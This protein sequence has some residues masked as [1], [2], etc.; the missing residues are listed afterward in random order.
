MDYGT[1][2]DRY[3]ALAK[4]TQDATGIATVLLDG[5]LAKLPEVLRG[6]GRVLHREAR[7]E[8]LAV[9]A[10]VMGLGPEAPPASRPRRVVYL[11]GSTDLRALAP[12]GAALFV[13]DLDRA[14]TIGVGVRADRESR[15]VHADAVVCALRATS[16]GPK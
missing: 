16:G 2:N 14:T 1:V 7:A 13:F 15:V 10:Q 3:I 8:V 12:G 5:H 4:G 6:L 9:R 11:R